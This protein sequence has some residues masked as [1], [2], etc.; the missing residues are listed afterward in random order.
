MRAFM[1]R[2]EPIEKNWRHT[3]SS[4]NWRQSQRMKK[5]AERKKKREEESSWRRSGYPAPMSTVLSKVMTDK[6]W[7]RTTRE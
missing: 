6:S 2:S 3:R 7:T 5:M 4:T 1:E